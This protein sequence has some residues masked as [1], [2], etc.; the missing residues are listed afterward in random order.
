MV[1]RTRREV[2]FSLSLSRFD[3]DMGLGV[4]GGRPSLPSR[5]SRCCCCSNLPGRR[6]R[7]DSRR[8]GKHQVTMPLPVLYNPSGKTMQSDNTA[9][10]MQRLSRHQDWQGI[11]AAALLQRA[12]KC[13]ARAFH[14]LQRL[15][16]SGRTGE[17][18][19]AEQPAQERFL[20]FFRYRSLLGDQTTDLARVLP[21][22]MHAQGRL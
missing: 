15:P 3:V 2:F 1:C 10:I 17:S 18:H 6:T 8:G 5:G 22:H 11:V 19:C 12:P 7:G 14:V 21:N 16:A 4:D 13:Q 20:V 9:G